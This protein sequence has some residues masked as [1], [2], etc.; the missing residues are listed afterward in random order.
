MSIYNSF[1]DTPDQIKIE[2]Q[3]ITLKFIRIDD[4]SGKLTWN[5]PPAME[6]CKGNGKYDGIVLTV[7]RKPANYIESSPKDGQYYIGDATVDGDLHAGS[8][9][10]DGVLVVGAFYNDRTTTELEVT[11]LERNTAYYF[12]GYA[13]D[14]VARYHREG[15]HSYSLPTGVEEGPRDSKTPGKHTV[16]FEENIR[17]TQPTGLIPDTVY[18]LKLNINDCEH[19]LDILGSEA[20]NY[21]ELIKTINE[22]LILLEEDI[23]SSPDFPNKNVIWLE[24]GVYYL[25]NGENRITLEFISND[26]APNLLPVG[27]LWFD[28]DDNLLFE[29]NGT[30]WDAL[31]FVN[32]GFDI[33]NPEDGTIWFDSSTG[34]ARIWKNGIWCELN[35]IVSN[36]NPLL[37]TLIEGQGYWYNSLTG[38]LFKL[39]KETSEWEDLLAIYYDK[40]PE[41]IVAGDYWY[42]EANEK[43][44]VLSSGMVWEEVPNVTVESTNS[45]IT[46]RLSLRYVVDE[47]S[48]YQ[49][50]STTELWDKIPVINNN[51]DPNADDS[52]DDG[53]FGDYWFDTND[54]ILYEFGSSGW[55]KLDN[56]VIEPKNSFITRPFDFRYVEDEQTLFEW[57][58]IS[59]SWEELDIASFPTDPR[60][61][62]SCQY[63]WDSSASV[64]NLFVW[65]TLSTQWAEVDNFFQR[66]TNPLEPEKLPE[67]TV[68]FNPETGELTK[69]LSEV[70]ESLNFI[71][72]TFDPRQ[73]PTGLYWL[74][75]GQFYLYSDS[76]MEWVLVIDQPIR[77]DTDPTDVEIGEYWLDTTTGELKQWD[78]TS[79]VVQ[80]VANSD[81]KPAEGFLWY[82]TVKDTLYIWDAIR[83]VETTAFAYVEYIRAEDCNDRDRIVFKTR[84]VGCDAIIEIHDILQ[85]VLGDIGVNVRYRDPVPGQDI[86]KSLPMY[87]QLGV[88]DDGSP[89]ERRQ[90]HRKIRE[91]LGAPTTKV[92]LSKSNIDICIDNALAMLRKFSG[93]SY[94]RGFFFLDMKRNQQ[95]YELSDKCVGFNKIVKVTAAYRMRGGF[96]KGSYGGYDIFGYAALKHLYTAGSFD[97]LSFHLVSSFIE[98]ME[99]IFA[100]RL[101]FQWNEVT[102]ELKLY[103]GVYA[104]ERVLLDVS[105]E[106][107]EQELLRDRNTYMW[108]QKWTLAE[109]KMML[110]QGRGKFQSLPGPSGSTIL[111]AQELITQ[112]EAE[113]A[114]LMD[115]LED[116]SMADAGEVGQKAYFIMG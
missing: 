79:W 6:G 58:S 23:W 92:E 16:Y 40:D 7:S 44:F 115:E 41:L 60:N 14:N 3:E 5:I 36:R 11:G 90:M 74:F 4:D 9:I 37:P 49:W 106:R 91:L 53:L 73:P 57:S 104:N 113:K 20:P 116:M 82:N 112:S 54:L 89:D 34:I 48:L 105:V 108:L 17:L 62:E 103:N 8:N 38:G 51:I 100:T 46:D 75:N 2:G 93:Y 59:L 35:T 32:Y 95:T 68:W 85:N 52:V 24:D 43:V 69:I 19:I 10:E 18:K 67:G 98:E 45:N 78:G 72:E 81:P 70:C 83:W 12:S 42:D 96:L 71:N 101:T 50:N 99:N 114:G 64:D 22:K 111:N 86:Q 15:V 109:A 61:R 30:G 110:S 65:D 66:D 56:V 80:V 21:Q 1:A 26:I 55:V 87:Q 84:K 25:W 94:K 27:T 76:L 102:R 97:I 77:S 28:T 107:T 29:Y 33:T 39:N 31:S 47:L 88:G 63:W 13:V